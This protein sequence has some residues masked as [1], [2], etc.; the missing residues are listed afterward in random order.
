MKSCEPCPRSCSRTRW[1]AGSRTTTHRSFV[2]SSAHCARMTTGGQRSF[3]VLSRASRSRCEPPPS[4]RARSSSDDHHAGT[5]AQENEQE[6]K[7]VIITKTHLSRRFVLRG[8]GAALALPRS[9][10][11]RVGKECRSRWSPY[12]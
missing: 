10:E 7:D 1:A 11:R 4:R 2:T 9:E 6:K 8:L 12:H 3:T 5:C